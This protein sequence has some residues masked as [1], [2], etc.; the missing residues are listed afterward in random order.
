MVLRAPGPYLPGVPPPG[1]LPCAALALASLVACAAARAQGPRAGA[2]PLLEIDLPHDSIPDEPKRVAAMRLAYGGPDRPDTLGG[3]TVDYVGHV[4]VERRGSTSQTLFPKIGYGLE[5]RTAAGADTS[6]SLLGMP[7]EED[8][9]LHGPYS[10]K[11]LIRNAFAYSLAGALTDYAPRVRFVELVLDGDYRGVYVL[12]E[13]IKRDG[14]R[15]AVARLD[16]DDLAGD[17]LTGGYILKVDKLT[18]EG[19]DG[20]GGFELPRVPLPRARATRLLHHYPRPRDIRREQ[21]DYIR[22]Y[23]EE[24]ERRLASPLFDDPSAGYAALVDVNSFVDYL[25]VNEVTR[26]VDAYRLSTFLHKDRD[27]RPGGGRLRMGPVWDFNLALANAGYCGGP[28]SDGWAFAFNDYC[29]DDPFYAPFWYPRLLASSLFR[30]RLAERYSALRQ[31]GALADAAIF[32]RFDSLAAAVPEAAARRNFARW[33]V[34]GEYTWPNAFVPDSRAE[35]LGHARD[36]L[37]RRLAWLDRAIAS[38]T[39]PPGE[40]E[41]AFGPNPGYADARLRGV[42]PEA[43]P[44]EVSWLDEAGRLLAT[45][46]VASAEEVAVP[47]AAGFYV[48]RLVSV[49]GATALGRFVGLGTR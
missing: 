49:D 10:D 8:W 45:A 3:T 28:R 43:F 44:A 26:N 22:A 33:P 20:I 40:L 24:F 25:I 35:A 11:T 36:Y 27:D 13:R 21:S 2:L 29:P 16:A 48:C 34:L 9:V 39:P 32:A 4:G 1:C 17:S 30:G 12:T 47:S 31:N 5:L 6:A 19:R 15:V 42:P 14:D 38:L 23:V 46:V 41:L 7:R 18:A 37:A